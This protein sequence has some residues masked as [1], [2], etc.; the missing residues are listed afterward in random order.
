MG[1][2]VA[3]VGVVVAVLSGVALLLGLLGMLSMELLF[4]DLPSESYSFNVWSKTSVL[5]FYEKEKG[6]I[7]HKNIKDIM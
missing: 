6:L 4:V 7:K 3:V 1:V 5:K 2:V